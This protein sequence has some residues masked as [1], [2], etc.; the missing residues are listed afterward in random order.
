[1]TTDDRPHRSRSALAVVLGVIAVVAVLASVL[2]TWAR[3]SIYDS[4][5]VAQAVDNA[6]RDPDLIDAL[7]SDLTDQPTDA[8]E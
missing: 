6:L 2:G 1:M 4:D 3:S 8:L 7:A 5:A